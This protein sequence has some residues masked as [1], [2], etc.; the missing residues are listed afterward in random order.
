MIGQW[1]YFLSNR[2]CLPMIRLLAVKRF[3]QGLTLTRVLSNPVL[4]FNLIIKH[5]IVCRW[6]YSE[7]HLHV[8]HWL[9][10]GGQ[11]VT[12]Q[13]ESLHLGIVR[14]CHETLGHQKVYNT[15]LQFSTKYLCNTFLILH[16]KICFYQMQKT[17]MIYL[18]E[19]CLF[20]PLFLSCNLIVKTIPHFQLLLQNNRTSHVYNSAF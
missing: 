4:N 16:L 15:F 17:Q 3:N 1:L 11:L 6:S 7:V 10:I 8:T 12:C 2:I 19:I 13:P 14:Y 20:L 9:G 5:T 18:I